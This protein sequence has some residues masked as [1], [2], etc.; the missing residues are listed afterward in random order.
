MLAIDKLTM[1]SQYSALFIAIQNASID[2]L[3]LT[4]VNMTGNFAKSF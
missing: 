2:S 4:N 3:S 1:N